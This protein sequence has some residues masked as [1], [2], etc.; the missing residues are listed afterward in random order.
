VCVYV[1]SSHRSRSRSRSSPLLRSSISLSLSPVN[2]I[3]TLARH[4][5][6][7][8][9]SPHSTLTVADRGGS[10]DAGSREAPVVIAMEYAFQIVVEVL[11]IV[12]LILSV[13]GLGRSSS[14]FASQ[15]VQFVAIG[16]AGALKFAFLSVPSTYL[17]PTCIAARAMTSLVT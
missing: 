16:V 15:R 10:L 14:A 13:F 2:T 7:F 3:R 17:P 12:L 11:N 4:F 8:K 9:F 6:L 5:G 1:C